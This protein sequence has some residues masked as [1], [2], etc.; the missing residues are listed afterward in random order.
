LGRLGIRPTDREDLAHEVFFEVHRH[1]PKADLDRPLRPW[2]FAFVFRVASSYRRLSRNRFEIPGEVGEHVDP[3]PLADEAL[4]RSQARA[5]IDRALEALDFDQRAVFILHD[6]DGCP[7]PEIAVLLDIPLNT[8]Y[9]R[10][11]LARA[12]FAAVVRRNQLPWSDP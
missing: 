5:Q 11:R 7:V 12:R 1:L 4:E 2:L 9:S 8:A 3:L 10:L 6:L